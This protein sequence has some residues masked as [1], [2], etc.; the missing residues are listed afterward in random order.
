MRRTPRR[1]RGRGAPRRASALGRMM[2]SVPAR[3]VDRYRSWCPQA[4]DYPSRVHELRVP[5]VVWVEAGGERGPRVTIVRP[6]PGANRAILHVV[7]LGEGL[8]TVRPLAIGLNI[9]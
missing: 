5:S 4:N 9:S 1:R 2:V 8:M 7:G 6:R 3:S